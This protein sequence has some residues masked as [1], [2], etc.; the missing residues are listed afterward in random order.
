[1][2]RTA[3]ALHR[4]CSSLDYKELGRAAG[5]T[6]AVVESIGDRGP[7]RLL[8]LRL[9]LEHDDSFSFTPG[10]WVDYFIP[11]NESTGGYSPVS[12]PAELPVLELAVQR[13]DWPPAAWVHERTKLGDVVYLRPGGDVCWDAAATPQ[14]TLMLAGGIGAT[15]FVSMLRHLHL[16][17]RDPARSL[18]SKA[19]LV[20]SY[21]DTNTSPTKTMWPAP[22]LARLA[23][24]DGDAAAADNRI[25]V[26]HKV[27]D[28]SGRGRM[29]AADV[30]TAI[31]FLNDNGGADRGEADAP[32][33]PFVCGPPT[34]VEHAAGLLCNS[35][36]FAE[37][38]VQVERW[39]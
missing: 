1:M 8:D 14:R 9:T 2:R 30:E 31:E 13:S 33:V 3:V 15:P 21:R 32:L 36:G 12:S 5:F 6:P 10:Q 16:A 28:G 4:R 20:H 23:G 25:Q 27:T 19:A 39:W 18:S 34:F 26:W 29:D 22:E 35:F 24:A 7:V 11:E 38:D 17:A 37:E